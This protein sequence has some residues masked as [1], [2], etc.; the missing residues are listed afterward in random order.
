MPNG[1]DRVNEHRVAPAKRLK[2]AR[3]APA[4][5]TIGRSYQIGSPAGGM[6]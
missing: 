3:A 2:Q 6:Q 5:T 4:A 1:T